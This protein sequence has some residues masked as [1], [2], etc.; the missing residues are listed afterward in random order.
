MFEVIKKIECSDFFFFWWKLICHG[1]LF[2]K[3]VFSL[4]FSLW[5][6]FAIL[7]SQSEIESASLAEE[8]WSLN[9]WSTRELT[10]WLTVSIDSPPPLSFGSQ[11][12][13]F[14]RLVIFIRWLDTVTA[15]LLCAEFCLSL[16]TVEVCFARQYS[17]I[18]LL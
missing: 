4:Y 18:S 1:F 9:H 10:P 7:V 14:T 15:V 12:C 8:V 17:W 13:F 2:E 5:P 16:K 3:F 6:S 11:N